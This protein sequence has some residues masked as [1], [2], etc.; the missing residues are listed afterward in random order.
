MEDQVPPPSKDDSFSTSAGEE[1]TTALPSETLESKGTTAPDK[2]VTTTPSQKDFQSTPAGEDVTTTPPS[3]EVEGATTADSSHLNEEQ[4]DSALVDE[5]TT[6]SPIEEP[7]TEP[8]TPEPSR[9]S[10]KRERDFHIPIFRTVYNLDD[11]GRPEISR[12]ARCGSRGRIIGGLLASV[13]E[14]PWAVVVK[15]KND[16]HYCGGTLISSRHVLTAAHCIGQ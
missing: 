4:E 6:E 15:D 14:W 16:V 11:F 2:N 8:G 3:E 7:S 9:L 5:Q 1:S 12:A 13:G 10:R